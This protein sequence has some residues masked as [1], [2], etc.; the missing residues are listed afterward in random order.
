MNSHRINS[1]LT[2]FDNITGGFALGQLN[3]VTGLPAMGKTAFAITLMVNIGIKQQIPVALFSLEMSNDEI[4]RRLSRNVFDTESIDKTSSEDRQSIDTQ[5]QWSLSD[6]PI[7]LDDTPSMDIEDIE[8]KISSMVSANGVKIAIIDY[9]QLIQGFEDKSGEIM[10]RLKA[11]ANDQGVCLI[12]ISQLYKDFYPLKPYNYASDED[13][14][15]GATKDIMDNSDAVVLLY[16]HDYYTPIDDSA[17]PQNIAEAI[18]IKSKNEQIEKAQ[19]YFLSE[20]AKFTD[21]LVEKADSSIK[22][23]DVIRDKLIN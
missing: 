23:V 12:T 18:I 6:A 2:N 17:E 4:I 3:T 8:G 21:Y 14:F 13:F 16:R 7:Y 15:R 1:G 22:V 20:F 9:L 19:L 5:K 11:M 10:M